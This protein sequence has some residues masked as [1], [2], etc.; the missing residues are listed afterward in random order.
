MAIVH[1]LALLATD[2]QKGTGVIDR[3]SLGF[4]L[5]GAVL[6]DLL[7]AH[8]ITRDLYGKIVVTDPTPTGDP[9]VDRA[10]VTLVADPKPRSIARWLG[11]FRGEEIR[12]DA[13]AALVASGDLR[14]TE[15]R[16]L[17][18]FRS[19][20][21]PATDGRRGTELGRAI[22]A[23]L[24]GVGKPDDHELALI[25]LLDAT[26]VLRRVFGPFDRQ[27]LKPYRDVDVPRAVRSAIQSA[28]VAA[29][30]TGAGAGAI[31]AAS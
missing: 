17:G 1:E 21:H 29:S 22:T 28:Q 16:T 10:L 18:L 15:H 25:G 13:L 20:R 7:L 3:T 30:S 9:I 14:E 23:V 6:A 27:T 26:G 24:S 2:P 11:R 19:T 4:G 5:G 12:R 31:A 8:R